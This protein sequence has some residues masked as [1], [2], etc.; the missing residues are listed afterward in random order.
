MKYQQP[1]KTAVAFEEYVVDLKITG[2]ENT[3][4]DAMSRIYHSTKEFIAL[5]KADMNKAVN[6]PK[7]PM[8]YVGWG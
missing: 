5:L 3:D 1:I 4:H 8:E 6:K 7:T 2:T